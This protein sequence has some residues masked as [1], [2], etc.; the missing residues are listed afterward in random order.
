MADILGI[1]LASRI[2]DNQKNTVCVIG[3]DI[4]VDDLSRYLDNLNFSK[5]GFSFIAKKDGRLIAHSTLLDMKRL[6]KEGAGEINLKKYYYPSKYDLNTFNAF[7]GEKNNILFIESGNSKLISIRFNLAEV[8]GLDADL[9]IGAPVSDFTEFAVNSIYI[10]LLISL[11]IGLI[12]IYLSFAISK[13]VAHPINKIALLMREIRELDFIKK[14]PEIDSAEHRILEI[15]RLQKSGRLMNDALLS[16]S[17]FVPLKIVKNLIELDQPLGPGGK[18]MDVTILFT[19]ISD[20]TT[21]SEEIKEDEL[22]ESMGE[23]LGMMSDIIYQHQ[24]IVDKF[25]GDAVM[26]IWGAPS[27]DPEHARHACQAVCECVKKI[28]ELNIRWKKAG[29]KPFYT[30]FGMHSGITFVGNI[31]SPYRLN[32]TALGD[33]VNIAARLETL[34]KEKGTQVLVSKEVLDKCGNSFNFKNLGEANVKG[35]Q[36]VVHVY[37]LCLDSIK[38]Y[39]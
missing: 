13:N 37:E 11:I 10:N 21:I 28:E 9:Y 19:D 5:N 31:G 26:A 22:V 30:R 4:L 7:A 23:Y 25:I 33:T 24:G 32:Y 6:K 34:N 17:K 12:M 15:D 20:F 38:S 39:K 16:F 29:R 3:V 27:P 8:I 14:Q 2:M 18:R 35:K 1:T 36:E